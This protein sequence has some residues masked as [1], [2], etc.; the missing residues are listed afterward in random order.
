MTKEMT[1]PQNTMPTVP[2][3][4]SQATL[5]PD[6]LRLPIVMII[7]EKNHLIKQYKDKYEPG[8]IIETSEGEVMGTP[9]ENG[10]HALTFIPIHFKRLWICKN[11][12]EKGDKMYDKAYEPGELIF[13]TEN[14]ADPRIAEEDEIAKQNGCVSRVKKFLQ[15]LSFVDGYEMPVIIS[16][17]KSS[18]I[19]GE[20]FLNK[21][22]FAKKGPKKL[23]F[24]QRKYKLSAVFTEY[25]EY[26]FYSFKVE[27]AGE[28]SEEELAL[29][30]DWFS[31]IASSNY[32]AE[33][34]DAE[35]GVE[36]PPKKK[37]G[38]KKRPA[39]EEAP[40]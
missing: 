23:D 7:Q 6:E 26:E 20:N 16:F 14:P 36:E 31:S 10:N 39:G 40:Y 24:W 25:K 21:L 12:R 9:D 18:R 28:P 1:K 5:M 13:R 15:F 27:K 17:G 34:D 38:K 37:N 19:A 30:K 8:M 29:C 4:D 35:E 32:Q 3:G 2:A 33:V 22:V 11:P